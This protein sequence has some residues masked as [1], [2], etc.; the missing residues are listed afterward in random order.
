MKLQTKGALH[1]KKKTKTK[2]KKKKKKKS[3]QTRMTTQSMQVRQRNREG[4]YLKRAGI[5]AEADAEAD[6][7][8][9]HL[10][11]HNRAAGAKEAAGAFSG[12]GRHHPKKATSV[13][14]L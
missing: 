4:R 11:G 3:V 6:R 7:L 10:A 2:K 12:G 1:L 14:L 5:V 13:S 8:S 9:H